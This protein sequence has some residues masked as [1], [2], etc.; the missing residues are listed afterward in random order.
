MATRDV[1]ANWLAD[2]GA[3]PGERLPPERQLSETLGISRGELRKAMTALEAEG[4][5][6]RHVGR[7]TFVRDATAPDSTYAPFV[8]KLS[9]ITSPH[10]AM[11]AR[12][13]LE[14]EVAGHAAIH[15]SQRQLTEARKLADNMRAAN[16]WAEY[17]TLDARLHELIAEATGNPLLVEL[18]RMVNAVRLAVVWS[19]LETPQGGPAK[20]YHSFAEHDA[21]ISALERRDRAAAIAAMRTHLKSVRAKLLKDD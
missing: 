5:V 16:T 20:D 2:Y 9:E 15:A 10:D 17:E 1:L 21:I 3:T 11:M 7:G 4:I 12:L 14:P 18:H 13:S 6:E 19:V 8:L